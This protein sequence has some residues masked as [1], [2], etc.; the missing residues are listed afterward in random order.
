MT[1]DV[2]VAGVRRRVTIANVASAD[3]RAAL[4]LSWIG[5]DGRPQTRDVDVSWRQDGLSWREVAGRV[6]DAVVVPAADTGSGYAVYLGGI[7]LTAAV[8]ARRR[9]TDAA[10]HG[11]SAEARDIRLVAPLPGRIVRVL[12]AAGDEVAARQDLV[13][14]EAMK[15][16]NALVAPR[17]GRVREVRVVDGTSVEAGRLLVVIAV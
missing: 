12:V 15:M 17:A 6:V 14:I 1:V 13:V 9:R 4:R 3:G 7:E 16:E 5:A 10:D 11:D 8:G 2:D